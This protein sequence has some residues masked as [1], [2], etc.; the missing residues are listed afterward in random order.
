VRLVGV[1][2]C[3]GIGRVKELLE[4]PGVGLD[5]RDG[6]GRYFLSLLRLA[7]R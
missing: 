4:C 5:F 3:G 6:D 2:G 7:V 1:V